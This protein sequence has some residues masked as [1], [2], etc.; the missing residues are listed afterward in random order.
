MCKAQAI[1]Q[2]ALD[3][4]LKILKQQVALDDALPNN[5]NPSG[6]KIQIRKIVETFTPQGHRIRYRF[7]VPSAP[8]N[9]KY[10]LAIMMIGSGVQVVR[11]EAY[12][13]A[14]GLLM[15][16]KPRHDQ[17]DKETLDEEDEVEVEVQAARG[18]PI[19]FVLVSADHK[20]IIPGTVVPYPIE[21]KGEKCRL[22]ARLGLPQAEA[23]LVYAEGLSPKAEVPFLSVSEGESHSGKFKVQPDGRARTIQ[24]PDV[25]GKA[26]G[27]L[28][29]T[30]DIE[31]CSAQV[32]IPW[33]KGSYHPL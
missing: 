25:N 11:E 2:T 14:T 7:N 26:S 15:E 6:L 31:G 27:V 33:G 13:N 4:G 8:E 29:V 23:V 18:E 9:E 3:K 5:T 1:E 22:E 10:S 20:L 24:L 12:V 17:E 21:S 32:E 19:R 30:V 28:K 16:Q